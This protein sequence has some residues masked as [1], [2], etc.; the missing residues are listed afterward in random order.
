MQRASGLAYRSCPLLRLQAWLR[1]VLQMPSYEVGDHVQGH[2][3]L[4]GGEP[5]SVDAG[6]NEDARALP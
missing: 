5:I 1:A 2:S 3:R 6:H 4:H